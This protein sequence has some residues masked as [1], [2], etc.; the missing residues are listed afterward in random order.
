MSPRAPRQPVFRC[1]LPL[2]PSVNEWLVPILRHLKPEQPLTRALLAKGL[3]VRTGNGRVV[4]A[5]V[6]KSKKAEKWIALARAALQA[7]PRPGSLHAGPLELRIHVF[8][9]TVS[10][11]GNNRLKLAE[12][13]FNELVWNDDRQV[14]TWHIVKDIDSEAPRVEIEVRQADA[15]AHPRVA[16]R[17]ARAE[18]EL[19]K[20]GGKTRAALAE[21]APPKPA[22]K[23]ALPPTSAGPGQ[24]SYGRRHGLVVDGKP[25]RPTK[26][27]LKGMAT[28]AYRAPVRG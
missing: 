22:W 2:P 28:P 9:P 27:A 4:T 18:K 8:V 24:E 12:D 26:E 11:D 14:V 19:A 6:V 1:T 5:A 10:S 16:Q 21:E 20:R 7:M 15:T 25:P 3:A 13:A 17:L 23:K